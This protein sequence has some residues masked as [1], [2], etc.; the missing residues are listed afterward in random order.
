M[1]RS[2]A[3]VTGVEDLARVYAS[4]PDAI[5]IRVLEDAARA[6]AQVI[7]DGAAVRAPRATG[8]LAGSMVVETELMSH[9]VVAKIGPTADAFHGLFQELG[10]PHHAA[11]PFL[12]PALDEDGPRAI[13]VMTQA[14]VIGTE[15]EA[16][17]LA[18]RRS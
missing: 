18:R 11:Q 12:R 16:A 6:G 8:E 3:R 5:E 14:M 4:L 9:G 13:A 10:T 1:A 7:A 15:R 2:I 17:R